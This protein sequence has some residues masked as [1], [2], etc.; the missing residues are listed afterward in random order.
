MKFSNSI[1]TTINATQPLN[2]NFGAKVIKMRWLFFTAFF[3]MAAA[4][5]L[6]AQISQGG[7]PMKVPPL[8]SRGIPEQVMPEV[9]HFELHQ[10]TLESRQTEP[11]LKPFRFAVGFDV[12]I[13]PENDGLWTSN[14]NGYDVWQVKIRSSNAFSISLVFHEFQLPAGAR[15]FVFNEYENHFIGAFTQTN[16][17]SFKKLAVAPV[18]GEEVVVQYEVPADQKHSNDFVIKEVFHDYVGILKTSERRPMG[19][20]AGSCN[21]DI[22]CTEGANWQNEKDAVLRIITTKKVNN[23]TYREICTGTLINNTAGD[24]TPYII[25]AAHCIENNEFAEESVFTFNYESPYC[26]PLDGDPANTISGSQL[27]A[28]SDSLDFALVELSLVPPPEFRPYYAGWDRRMV[29]PD[30]TVSIHHPQGDIKKMAYD[31]D[32]PVYSNFAN[33]YTPSG[34]LKVLRWEGGVTEN[35][36]S[37]GPLFSPEKNLIGTL[38]GGLATCSNPVNDYFSRF[39]MAWE[40]RADS[41]RQLRY[42]LDPLRSGKETMNGKRFYTDEDLCLAYTHLEEFDEHRNVVLRNQGQFAGYWGGS[43]SEGITEFSERFSLPGNVR[44]HGVTL[45][46]GKNRLTAGP[47]NQEIQINVYNGSELPVDLIHSESFPV[48]G[49][50]PDA[51]N[52]IQFSQ[53]VEP[54]DTF[55]VAFELKNMQPQDS[56]V[57]YQSLRSP[58]NENF[59]WFKKDGWWYNFKEANT[60][61]ASMVNVFELVACNVSELVNDTPLVTNPREAIIYPNPTRGIFTFEAGLEIDQVNIQVFNLIGQEVNAG[62]SGHLERKIQINLAGNNPDVYFVRLKTE[63]GI[64]SKKVTYVPW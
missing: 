59:F 4:G 57:V 44:L 49:M 25:T 56:F 16:N 12:T 23:R 26:A 35:G 63:S 19:K 3:V 8:K 54:A 20:T 13:S 55:F 28:I 29:Y 50:V 22:N 7:Q 32:S 46:V 33:G 17:K 9:N 58:E 61:G 38:T 47:A 21:I 34:F 41:A 52:F 45:G 30:S 64:I 42:W 31:S 39:D 11:A 27:K 60:D 43:N 2:I 37:G 6:T 53:S 15:L 36:S 1:F 24:Q 10:K 51:M 40:F 5:F 48:T 14:L 18:T 62:L